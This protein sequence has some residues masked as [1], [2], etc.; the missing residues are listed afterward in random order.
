MESNKELHISTINDS[1][2]VA[3]SNG[4]QVNYFLFPEYEIHYNRIAPHT[5]QEW[6]FHQYIEETLI[7]VSG[8]LNCKWIKSDKQIEE[9]T[10]QKNDVIRV[11]NSIHTFENNTDEDTEFIV[12]RFVPDGHDKKQ[13][14]KNDK[15]IV[16]LNNLNFPLDKQ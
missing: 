9:M 14:I 8:K 2:Y 7:I 5:I 10:V 6:H 3:K 11:G 4:T 1:I 13:L 16:D 15:H 12:F